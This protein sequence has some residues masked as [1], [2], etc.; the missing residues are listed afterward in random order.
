MKRT[1]MEGAVCP[2]ARSLDVIGDWWSLL[3]V[4]DAQA[5]LRR[6]G[7][8]QKSL[9][10]A[11]NIL[12]QRLRHLVD[13]GILETRPASDGSAWQEYVLTPKG[14]SLFPIMVALSQWG[15]EHCFEPGE[16][17]TR[18][19]DREQ[20]LPLKPLEIRAADGRPITPQDVRLERPPP[21]GGP[22]TRGR[23]G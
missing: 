9:G 22:H 13:H 17:R 14:Q 10:V 5:G 15:V 1:S 23:A 20:G 12:A 16:R 4:R 3:I 2:V 18:M 8:F 7:E 21:E 11:K 19:L 6:F